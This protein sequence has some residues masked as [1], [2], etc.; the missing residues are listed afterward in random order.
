VDGQSIDEL[1]ELKSLRM[2]IGRMN[3]YLE[4]IKQAQSLL[5]SIGLGKT[6]DQPP[7]KV[8]KMISSPVLLLLILLHLISLAINPLKN[9]STLSLPILMS[10]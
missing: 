5:A 2:M 4:R 3:L 1:E 9:S 7:S 10:R 8:L 6:S